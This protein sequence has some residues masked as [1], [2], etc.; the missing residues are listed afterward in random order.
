MNL[1]PRVTPARPDLAARFL[2][3]TVQAARFVDG[4]LREVVDPQAP[5]RREPRPD[6]ALDTEVLK[7]ERVMVYDTT[8][9]GWAWVQLQSDR[10]VG[11]MPASALAT[12][13]PQPTHRVATLRAPLLMGASIKMPTLEVLPFGATLAVARE[14]GRFGIT[15]N[16]CYVPLVH[17]APLNVFESDFVAVAERFLGTPYVWGGKTNLGLD[18]SALVQIS[19]AACGVP[20]PRDS[21]MQ[22]TA[23]GRPVEVGGDLSGV[24]RGDLVFWK[25]HV[26]I[27]RDDRHL[28]H[29]NGFHM[30]VAIEPIH[31]ALARFA[32]EGNLVTGV[33]R[34]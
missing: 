19:L 23:L 28:L 22:E 9:D 1:D 14:E 12:P 15:A 33:R 34:L 30:A 24:R 10:Y 27:V 6:A 20:C 16:G 5:V 11:W 32:T 3:G 26:A 4:E 31:D 8:E 7:G 2:E 29:A 17:L 25:G 13:G 18:C 21:Y